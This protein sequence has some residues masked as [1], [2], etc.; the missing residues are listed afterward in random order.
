MCCV[1]RKYRS[2]R[3]SPDRRHSLCNTDEHTGPGTVAGHFYI[4]NH[5]GRMEAPELKI[6]DGFICKLRKKLSSACDGENYIETVWS[7]GYVLRDPEESIESQV[8]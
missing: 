1:I 8:A 6:I 4:S 5:N 3:R 2:N 7:R